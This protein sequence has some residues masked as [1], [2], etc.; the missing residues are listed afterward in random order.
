MRYGAS[1]QKWFPAPYS[2]FIAL[3]T[4]RGGMD[5]PEEVSTPPGDPGEVAPEDELVKTHWEETVADMEATAEQYREEGWTVLE[6]HPGDVAAL[7][8]GRT[9]RWGLDLL[10]PDDEF[11]ELHRWVEADGCRF[12]AF[13][14]YR[15]EGGG[16]VYAVVAM[17]DIDAGRAVLFPVYYD[18]A[19]ASA[20]LDAAVDEGEMRT[21]L[22]PLANDPVVTFTQTDP[23][24]FTA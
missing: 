1:V 17:Q 4:E 6:V 18:P 2:G 22:R 15:G 12:D 10:V 8:P 7:S 14:V 16:V 20:L 3:A 13:E 23:S 5:D 9:D 19:R 11:E 24:L 21:H